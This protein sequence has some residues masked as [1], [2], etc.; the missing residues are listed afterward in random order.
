VPPVSPTAWP[1]NP[2]GVDCLGRRAVKCDALIM[3][4]H[5]LAIHRCHLPVGE[6]AD[7]VW[8]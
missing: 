4:K 8:D 2:L 6:H 5:D 3:G 1:P 7:R